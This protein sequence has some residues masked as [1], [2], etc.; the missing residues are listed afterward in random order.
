MTYEATPAPQAHTGPPAAPGPDHA[1]R[2]PDRR[3]VPAPAAVAV[4]APAQAAS[5]DAVL[6]RRTMAEVGPVADKVTSYFYALL[7]VR[8]P[9][10]RPLF[11]AAMDTQRDRLLRALLTAAEH[12]D[13]T[14]VL[15]AY[16]KNLGRGHRKYGTRPEHYPA[17]GECLIGSL[18]RYAAGLGRGD[19]GCLGPGVH[20]DLA[21]HDRRRG[22]GR[23]AGPGLVVRRGRLA[24]PQDPG[25]R[26]HHG[27]PRP[28]VP[29]PRRAV[30]EPGDALVAADLAA[31][32]LRLGAPLRRTAVVPRE[33]RF[34]RA[35][36]PTR[37]CTAPAP[38]TSSGSARRPAR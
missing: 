27:P 25:R 21:G 15:V 38:A 11:P 34:R 22:R 28:A 12:I 2:V 24:R 17:V 3:S 20:D 35:G 7:F 18:S 33:G 16:L 32:L 14:E 36:S 13:N 8:H 26:R 31:L 9:E 23:T 29:L 30:H 19:R 4:P 10:L 1:P 37:W 6:I 5:P